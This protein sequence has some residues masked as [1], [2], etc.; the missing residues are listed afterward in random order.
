VERRELIDRR[1][2][3][4]L[5]ERAIDDLSFYESSDLEEDRPTVVHATLLSVLVT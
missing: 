5:G 4:A 1:N 2:L 3:L